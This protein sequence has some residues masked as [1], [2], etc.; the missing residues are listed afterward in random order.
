[1]DKNAQV[2]PGSSADK[3]PPPAKFNI[4]S[5]R[6]LRTFMVESVP[7]IHFTFRMRPFSLG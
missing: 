3:D 2:R 1:M 5:S 7:V 6:T 4:G